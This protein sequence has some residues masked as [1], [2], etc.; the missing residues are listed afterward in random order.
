MN[1]SALAE[2]IRRSLCSEIFRLASPELV[3]STL[4]T[5]AIFPLLDEPIIK[6]SGQCFSNPPFPLAFR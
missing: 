1:G 4:T 2:K 6:S 3:K 5:H